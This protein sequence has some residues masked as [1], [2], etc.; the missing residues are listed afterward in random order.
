MKKP[1][2]PQTYGKLKRYF[3]DHVK[4][5]DEKDFYVV[6]KPLHVFKKVHEHRGWSECVANLVIPKGAVIYASPTVFGAD[7]WDFKQ[8]PLRRDLHHADHRKMR[9]SEARVHSIARIHDGE[10]TDE[11]RSRH[12]AHFKYLP[13]TNVRPVRKFSWRQEQ[14]ESGIHFFLNVSDA[15]EYA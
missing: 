7:P 5:A 3:M 4:P 11:A 1:P 12:D 8:S 6:E 2:K 10:A 13:K 14:C 9:C 15:I